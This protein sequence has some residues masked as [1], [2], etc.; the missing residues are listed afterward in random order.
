[1]NKEKPN[2]ESD[3]KEHKFIY[4]PAPTRD[5]NVINN[6]EL[7]TNLLKLE[8]PTNSQ[9]LYVYSVSLQPPIAN[10]NF[11]LYLKIQRNIDSELNK[12]FTRK[13][14]SGYNLFASSNTKN[15]KINIKAK[16]ENIDYDI[17]FKLVGN[18]DLDKIIDFNGDNQRKK[19]FLERVIKNILL[20]NKNTIKFGDSRTIVKLN[21]KNVYDPSEGKNKGETVYKGYFTAAQITESGLYLLVLNTSKHVRN[22]TV[23]DKMKELRLE[24]KCMSE[25]EIRIKIDNYFKVHKTVLATYGSLRTYRIES[26]DHDSSPKVKSFNIKQGDQMKTITV[27]DYYKQQYNINIRDLEQPL[28]IAETKSTNKNN[29]KKGNSGIIDLKKGDDEGNKPVI[30]LIPEL[31]YITG[32]PDNTEKNKGRPMLAKNKMGPN[33]KM[34]EILAINELFKSNKGKQFKTRDGRQLTSKSPLE[35]SNEWGISLG[36]NLCIKGRLLPQPVL[37]YGRNQKKEPNNGRFQS[38]VTYKGA[39]I[40]KDNFIYIY[41]ENDKSNIQ[42]DLEQLLTKARNKDI[43]V[44]CRLGDMKGFKIEKF[45]N[46]EDLNRNLN[47]LKNRAAKIEMAIVFLSSK[48][49]KY[50]SQLKN[51]FTNEVK[52]ATQFVI[53]KKLNEPKRAGSIMF[54]IVEQ[55]NAK[56]GGTNYKIDCYH[57]KILKDDKIYMIL[58]LENRQTLNGIDYAMTASVNRTFDKIKTFVYSITENKAE[59]KQKAV[60]DLLKSALKDLREGGSPRPP[61]YIILFRQGGNNVQNSRLAENE[62][63]IFTNFLKK[64]KKKTKFIYI[65]CNL[66]SELKFFEK[67]KGGYSNP[68]SGICVD[69][70]VTQSDKFE[71]FIQPQFVNQGTATPCHYQVLYED[72]GSDLEPEKLHELCYFLSYYFWTWSGAI[73]VPAVLKLAITAMDFYTKHLGGRLNRPD[74]KFNNPE[75]I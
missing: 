9:K 30:Y 55:I 6:I 50:Y 21:S 69:R 67:N 16:V 39:E 5:I 2:V 20:N 33:E 46:W 14:F 25:S 68:R 32:N 18:F 72:E 70:S 57:Q 60:E 15:D 49:E 19:S 71:F 66:K 36:E 11:T 37:L 61:D 26:I 48:L 63:P 51:F 62:V 28:I 44:Q 59:E 40:N 29:T 17:E 34:K 38:G 13:C 64:K 31:V 45:N 53:S 24:S 1:M 52:F 42:K 10:D 47:V 3:K 74:K 54:N 56:M 75:Y 23:Y 12:I 22:M 4:P 7:A 41:D 65:C 35:L 58:G 27:A 8:A 43:N 73:R